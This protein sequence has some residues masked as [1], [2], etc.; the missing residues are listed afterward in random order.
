M[1]PEEEFVGGALVEFFGGPSCASV[2]DGENPPDLYLIVGMSRISVEVTR[3]SQP[4]IESDGT[5]GKQTRATQDS[6]GQRLL[7]QLDATVGP[8]LPDD[9]TLQ[10]GLYVPVPNP[11]RFQK[12]LTKLVTKIAS[13][14]QKGL[15]QETEIAGS[16]VSIWVSPERPS[17]KKIVGYVV[18]TNSSANV[19][20][21]ARLMLED[22]ISTKSKV[23]ASLPKPIWLALLNDSYWLADAH[24]YAV[25]GRQL[26]LDHCFECIFLVSDRGTVNEL[27]VVA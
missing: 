6:F 24:T 13:A 10:I 1:R 21:N 22:R 14:P 25:A 18:S 26:K 11:R 7:D 23:C 19:G 2:S 4:A 27:T 20:L 17:E 16:R 9:V 12:D 5:P 8:S 15:E 3:L